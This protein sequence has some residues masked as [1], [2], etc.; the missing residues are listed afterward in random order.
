[1]R[2]DSQISGDAQSTLETGFGK[3]RSQVGECGTN[4]IGA[5]KNRAC[6]SKDGARH[7]KKAT[8]YFAR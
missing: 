2:S 6:K 7:S 5:T 8:A 3:C 4:G 1:M